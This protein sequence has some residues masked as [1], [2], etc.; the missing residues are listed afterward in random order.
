MARG[1]GPI[2]GLAS[3][4]DIV[5][6]NAIAVFPPSTQRSW[7]IRHYVSGVVGGRLFDHSEDGNTNNYLYALGANFGFNQ[8]FIDPTHSAVQTAVFRWPL[9]IL[10]NWSKLGISYDNSLG[11]NLPIVWQDGVQVVVSETNTPDPGYTAVASPAPFHIGNKNTPTSNWGG[12]IS[13]MSV[14]DTILTSGE[15]A[16]LNSGA[17]PLSIQSSL[18]QSSWKLTGLVSPEID[19]SGKGHSAFVTGTAF[20]LDPPIEAVG[21][22]GSV[23]SAAA[24]YG[25]ILITMEGVGEAQGGTAANAFGTSDFLNISEPI[26]YGKTSQV[27]VWRYRFGKNYRIYATPPEG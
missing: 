10:N 17:S 14:W 1:F 3:T 4:D 18:L 21:S 11:T 7:F 22:A 16:S 13:E 26:P 8:L 27:G 5:T 2:L 25:T 15:F 24:V 6:S 19:L 20:Q 12:I 23:G 9:P